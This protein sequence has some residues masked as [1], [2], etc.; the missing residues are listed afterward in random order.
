MNIFIPNSTSASKAGEVPDRDVDIEGI[1]VIEHCVEGMLVVEHEEDI[2]VE[3]E[4]VLHVVDVE[5]QVVVESEVVLHVVQVLMLDGQHAP[6]DIRPMSDQNSHC[7]RSLKQTLQLPVSG[8]QSHRPQSSSQ[9]SQ[10]RKH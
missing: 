9:P 6:R 8:Q 1:L 10:G 5:G 7:P 3:S 4:A 2:E